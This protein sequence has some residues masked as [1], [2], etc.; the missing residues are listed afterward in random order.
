MSKE[1]GELL[2]KLKEKIVFDLDYVP[3][4]LIDRKSVSIPN[5]SEILE[6]KRFTSL[7]NKHLPIF[8]YLV[9]NPSFENL[10]K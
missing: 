6:V 7:V 3:I 4:I 5:T 2:A 1:M 8:N 9:P 10:T